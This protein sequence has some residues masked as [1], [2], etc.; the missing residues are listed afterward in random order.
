[1]DYSNLTIV[2]PPKIN[3]GW[4]RR[5]HLGA[6][7]VR[8]SIGRSR[9]RVA[10]GLYKF[11][12]PGRDSEVLVTSNYKLSFD[13]LRRNLHGMDA[14]I[15]V[16]QTYGINVWCAA[17]KGTFGTDELI[18]RINDTQLQNLVS[19]KR[20]IV[21]QLGAPGVSA[22]KV[23]EATGF[24]VKFGPVRAEDIKDYLAAG[25]KKNQTVRTVQFNIKDRLLLAPV[26]LVNSW[27][28]LL[29]ALLLF[30][31]LSGLYPGGYSFSLIRQESVRAGFYL[32]A[33]Y[34]SGAFLT[35]VLLPWIP[36]RHFGGKGLVAGCL[37]FGMIMLFSVHRPPLPGMAGWFLISGAVSSY[38]AMNFTGAST[39]TSLSGVRKEMRLF[40]PL[41]IA[42]TGVGL[43]LYVLS[44]LI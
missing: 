18:H 9:Y 7:R 30:V 8:L 42:F 31:M 25:Y 36:F 32:A 40:V 39:Y 34:F 15:L 10:P 24:A 13:V 11:G 16:L 43:A 5:D 38:L 14:W 33:A 41:Q 4:T 27:K 35:P 6:L 20:I 29:P 44:K 28:Y 26:E 37:T 12:Q 21:P 19:H 17:G 2:T 22:H 23:K 3:S 1:M